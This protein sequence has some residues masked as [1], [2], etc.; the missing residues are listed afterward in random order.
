MTKNKERSE[1]DQEMRLP[2]SL[3]LFLI[4]SLS[5]KPRYTA[6]LGEKQPQWSRAGEEWYP[7]EGTQHGEVDSKGYEESVHAVRS[8]P[9]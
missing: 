3:P 2:F 8:K 6:T 7:Q 9:A 1:R 4:N 5:L